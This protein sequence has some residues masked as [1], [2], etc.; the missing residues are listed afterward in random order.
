MHIIIRL[1]WPTEKQASDIKSVH[2]EEASSEFNECV[3]INNSK[4][5]NDIYVF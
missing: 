3:N 2:T 1:F 5:L 4:Q